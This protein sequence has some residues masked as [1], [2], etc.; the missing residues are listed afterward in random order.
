MA[1]YRLWTWLLEGRNDNSCICSPK[2]QLRASGRWDL[3][4]NVLISCA[5]L[6]PS[7]PR[8]KKKSHIKAPFNSN[9]DGSESDTRRVLPSKS[10]VTFTPHCC[11]FNKEKSVIQPQKRAWLWLGLKTI[12]CIL[13]LCQMLM[14]TVLMGAFQSGLRLFPVFLEWPSGFK[15]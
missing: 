7:F 3:S 2:T 14:R 4:K 12:W 1:L 15:C 9:N 8:G 10:V 11:L 5:H 6:K 13:G